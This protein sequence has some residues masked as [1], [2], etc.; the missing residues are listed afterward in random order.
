MSNQAKIAQLRQQ[1]QQAKSEPEARKI[2]LE[3]QKLE[4]ED[5]GI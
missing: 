4:R 5:F 3:I 2:L 1:Y